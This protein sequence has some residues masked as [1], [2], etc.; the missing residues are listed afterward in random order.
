MK[1]LE[2]KKSLKKVRKVFATIGSKINLN[3]WYFTILFFIC[4]LVISVFVWWQCFQNP[5]PSSKVLLKIEQEKVNYREMKASTEQVITTLQDSRE[6]FENPPFFGNQRELFL[7][8]DLENIDENS[9]IVPKKDSELI[10]DEPAE[11]IIP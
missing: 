8:I 9:L 3:T 6:K 7:E 10:P 5:L 1:K 11:E 2:T 4:I